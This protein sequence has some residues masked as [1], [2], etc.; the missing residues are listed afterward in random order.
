M[1]ANSVLRVDFLIM[2][3]EFEPDSAIGSSLNGDKDAASA[4][5]IHPI[6]QACGIYYFEVE[7]LGKDQKV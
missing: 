1:V 5:T 6:P 3:Q 4:R 7:I 2:S